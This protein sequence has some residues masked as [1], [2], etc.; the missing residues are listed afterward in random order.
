MQAS[1]RRPPLPR[2]VA[3]YVVVVVV[4]SVLLLPLSRL[5]EGAVHSP[6]A[7]LA[8]LVLAALIAGAHRYPVPIGPKRKLNTGT[9]PEV[10][11]VLLLP[12]PL[13][14]LAPA[15]AAL[16]GNLG[17]SVRPIHVTRHTALWVLRALAGPSS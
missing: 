7:A 4:G 10:A 14:V 9:A 5:A 8:A 2:R 11:A 12:G 13:A 6:A 1:V 3:L 16:A 15:A 17:P